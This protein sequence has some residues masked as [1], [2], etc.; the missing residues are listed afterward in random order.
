MADDL[1][2]PLSVRARFERF[3]ATVKGAFVV[4]GE[5]ANPHLVTFREARI[6]P[7]GGR[8]GEVI[9]MKAG[10]LDIPPHQDTFLPFEFSIADLEAGWY[11]L[12]C[13]L[14]VDGTPQTFDGGRRFSVPWPRGAVRR[15][16]VTVGQK[17]ELGGATVALDQIE[18]TGEQS[19]L[20]FTVQP[21]DDVTVKL[22]ADG[23][24]LPE[25]ESAADGDSGE[26]RHVA[27]PLLRAHSELV[28]VVRR[29][30][31]EGSADVRLT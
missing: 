22:I 31:D 20:R 5:D 23:D 30:R 16:T 11:G 28:I 19:A 8:G 4:R 2:E 25:L 17:V 1:R 6:V 15:G 18:V 12:E 21:P 10:T 14:E 29:G 9:A 24:R 27:F 3:P 7:V 13:E 26:G